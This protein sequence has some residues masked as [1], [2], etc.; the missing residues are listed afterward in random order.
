MAAAVLG[1][2]IQSRR[3]QGQNTKNVSND[4]PV[5]TY[6][7]GGTCL[8]FWF[9]V[10]CIYCKEVVTQETLHITVLGQFDT[11]L[12]LMTFFQT[13]KFKQYYKMWPE[14]KNYTFFTT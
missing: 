2:A 1:S 5:P 3:H 4:I 12:L 13:F 11:T 7:V 14:M 8:L 10:C 6:D 9:C